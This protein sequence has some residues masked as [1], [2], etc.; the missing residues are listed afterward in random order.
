MTEIFV[1]RIRKITSLIL[2]SSIVSLTLISILPC[3]AEDIAG[4][5]LYYNI[6]AIKNKNHTLLYN[7][8]LIV[9]CN[10]ILI[11]FSLLSLTG[12]LLIVSKKYLNVAKIMMLMVCANI[13]FSALSVIFSWIVIKDTGEISG[14]RTPFILSGILL[15]YQYLPLV[16]SAISLFGSV[17]Y[18]IFVP[19]FYF[20]YFSELRKQKKIEEKHFEEKKVPAKPLIEEKVFVKKPSPEKVTSVPPPQPFVST[21]KESFEGYIQEDHADSDLYPAPE[22]RLQTK[23]D[24]LPDEKPADTKMLYEKTFEQ[25]IEPDIAKQE[26]YPEKKEQEIPSPF[27]KA[28]SSSIEKRRTGANKVEE[29]F[30]QPP[31]KKKLTVRCP[32][33]KNIFTVEKEEGVFEIKIECPKCGRKGV[34]KQ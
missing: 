23:K 4:E 22:R 25:E 31:L 27:E 34:I 32:E 19:N 21:E 3:F 16:S 15:N 18:L 10:W 7:L 5:V 26:E 9:I 17:L 24:L 28:L 14:A 6:D 29:F 33:C 13:I 1:A 8:N 30:E 20:K 11:V 2:I 12:T